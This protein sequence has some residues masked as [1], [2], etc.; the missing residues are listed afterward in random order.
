M[1]LLEL[2]RGARS[3]MPRTLL[4]LTLL[5]SGVSCS[6]QTDGDSATGSVMGGSPS[7]TLAGGGGAMAGTG[8]LAGPGGVAGIGGAG[9]G[10]LGGALPGGGAS[11]GSPAGGA[12]EPIMPIA[13][14]QCGADN[15]G[16]LSAEQIG[17]LKAG[18]APGSLRVLYP[19]DGTVFPRGLAAP[20]LMWEGAGSD[21]IYVHLKATNFE[22]WGCLRASADGQ[23]QLP[24]DIW[25]KAGAQSG[26]RNDPLTV[27][28]TTLTGQAATGPV[29]SRWTIAQ[30]T[31]KGSIYYNSYN[32]QLNGSFGNNGAILRLKPG[33]SAEIFA[34]QGT[35]SGCHSVA[36]NGQRMTVTEL[37][38]GSVVNGLGG[39]LSSLGG[40]LGGAGGGIAGGLAS[41]QIYG[42]TPDTQPNPA[43]LRS[44]TTA[45]F[46]GLTPDGSL[47]LTSA[48]SPQ[49]GPLLQGG[50]GFGMGNAE[51]H[52]TDTGNLVADSG[53]PSN[54]MMP[55]FSADGS[56]LVFSDGGQGGHALVAMDFD[57]QQ[58]KASN[59]RTVYTD[60]AHFLGW[61]FVL[62]DNRAVVFAIT[63]NSTFSGNGVGISPVVSRGPDSDLGIVDLT[64]GKAMLLAQAIG[65]RSAADADAGNTYL[66]FGAEELHQLYYPTVSPVSAGGYF[67]LFFDSVRHYGN[68]G[69]HRQLWG[70]A[71]SIAAVTE[72]TAGTYDTDPSFP[73]FYLSGQELP[74]ANH[75]A[76]TALDPCRQDGASCETGVDC[77]SGFCTN[78]MC[79]RD[80]QRC[81]ETNEACTTSSDCCNAGDSCIGGFCGVVLQ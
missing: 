11:G 6:S 15:P 22:Y 17:S 72:L 61:P 59:P 24:Q 67:W 68:Q 63:S 19:Y 53:I 10:A 36:A 8:S 50:V 43:P 41:S 16:G 65:F 56:L 44:T 37:G 7:G 27:E 49:V 42:L 29:S 30:A 57:R 13:I 21:G 9:G 66:P 62:P 45:S 4:G 39:I 31:L 51:L 73:A 32:T 78:G 14:D 64:T 79:G 52:E 3:A 2:R 81:S 25:D 23:V 35:C 1:N 70:A 12:N 77:C 26:G 58:R 28:L 46:S 40:G 71:I 33:K 54:A 47:Y 5:L 55:T 20:T 76:F 80:V 38:A 48:A 74:V 18:G 60:N 69:M 75:R 34:R